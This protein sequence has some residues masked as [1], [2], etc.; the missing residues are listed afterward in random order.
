MSVPSKLL[1]ALGTWK[2]LGLQLIGRRFTRDSKYGFLLRLLE[3]TCGAVAESESP[4][5]MET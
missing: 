5:G 3:S 4:K 1:A 2:A